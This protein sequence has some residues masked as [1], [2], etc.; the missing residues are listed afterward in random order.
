[1]AVSPL[2]LAQ[3]LRTPRNQDVTESPI[4]RTMILTDPANARDLVPA[5]ERPLTLEAYNARRILCQ[6]DG[7]AAPSLLAALVDAG[8]VA[9]QDGLE[10][11][12]SML[13]GED[14]WRR[15]EFLSRGQAGLVALLE[16]ARP[17]VDDLP[18]FIE[19]DFRGRICDLA[20]IIVRQLMKPDYDQ[21]SFRSLDAEERDREIAAL[22]R[23]GFNSQLA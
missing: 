7:D 18:D 4:V 2:I 22:R 12:W 14:R 17:M 5:L 20:F 21:S 13:T 23:G 19:R 3:A 9:R 8:T 15:G 1:M 10:V 6:F 16:D 11:L